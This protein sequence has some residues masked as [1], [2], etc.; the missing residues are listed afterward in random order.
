MLF[1]P[2]SSSSPPSSHVNKQGRGGWV[3]R[4]GDG[5]N[6]PVLDETVPTA[7]FLFSV[8]TCSV[9]HKSCFD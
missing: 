3:S 9:K 1:P 6:V 7:S 5:Q 8:H 4:R 2:S